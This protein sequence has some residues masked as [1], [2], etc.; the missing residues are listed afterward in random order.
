MGQ[1]FLTAPIEGQITWNISYL[2]VTNGTNFGF[3]DPVFGASRRATLE[4]AADYAVSR[5]D[6]SG[7]IDVEVQLSENNL[8]SLLASAGAFRYSTVNFGF[9]NGLA[10][11]HAT[12]GVD[13]SSSFPD[14]TLMFNFGRTWNSEMDSPTASEFDLFSV[15]I[16]EFGHVFGLTSHLDQSGGST[17]AEGNYSVFDS[18]LKDGA[19]NSLFTAGAQFVGTPAD[20]TGGDLFFAGAN[21]MAANGGQPVEVYVPATFSQGTSIAHVDPAMNVIMN[22]TISAGVEQRTY[23]EIEWAIFQDLGYTVLTPVPE[24]SVVLLGGFFLSGFLLQR[25]RVG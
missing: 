13:A 21:A 23:D 18:F 3:D 22:P 15:A 6:H 17:I 24:P 11:E 10:F 14:G 19:G 7:T 5:F 4:A 20:L 1:V 16:H 25:R 12:T 2:D 8:S 9:Q